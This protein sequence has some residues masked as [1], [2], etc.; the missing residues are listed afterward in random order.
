MNY[1]FDKDCEAQRFEGSLHIVGSSNLERI[2]RQI[3]K[4]EN[5]MK[6]TFVQLRREFTDCL[7]GN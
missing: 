6:K 4:L 3:D 5:F 1:T 2:V 7:V